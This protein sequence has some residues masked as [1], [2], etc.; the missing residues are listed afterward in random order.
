MFHEN[1]FSE[2]H[3]EAKDE[4]REKGK[5]VSVQFVFRRHEEPG[6]T[7]TGMSADFLTEKG[8]AGAK[9]RGHDLANSGEYVMFFG[10]KGVQRARETAGHMI[11]TFRDEAGAAAL[12]NKPMTAED[13]QRAGHGE[14]PPGDVAIYRSS[15]LN[16][17]PNFA[18]I[19]EAAK[20]EGAKTIDESVQYWLDNPEKAKELAAGTP[21]E[22]A[23]E[24]AHRLGLGIK[25]SGKL[26]EDT[27]L[28]VEN[29]TH[30]PKLEALLHEVMIDDT[31]KRGFGR[32]EEM[33][34]MFQP[35]EDVNLAIHRND[36]GELDLGGIDFRG[37]HY[38]VDMERLDELRDLY[39]KMQEEKRKK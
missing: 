4:G 3:R 8:I 7:P 24:L 38:G 29:L 32:L 30:G 16:P 27:N 37:K 22:T 39:R 12:I 17:V 26:Y 5:N 11:G 35:G 15:D 31:G 23:A 2:A 36:E 1:S 10:S 13:Q 21:E 25:M 28:R 18:K 14:L 20:A 19:N 6:K 9:Q 34:G 33:G